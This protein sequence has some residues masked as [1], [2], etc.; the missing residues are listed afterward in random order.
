M[1]L[2]PFCAN[3]RDPRSYLR[4]PWV[5]KGHAYACNGQILVRLP[6]PDQP[7]AI[8]QDNPLADKAA[9]LLKTAGK[10]AYAPLPEFEQ[11]KRCTG[12][13]GDGKRL[14]LAC[15]DCDGEGYFTRGWHEYQC[16]ECDGEG[17]L[18]ANEGTEG[19]AMHDCPECGGFGFHHS[20]AKVGDAAYSTVYLRMLAAL[21]GLRICT[22]GTNHGAHF[23]FDG[24]EGLLMPRR[25]D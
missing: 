16:K 3:S 13:G 8:A 21:P 22:N 14:M 19:A 10:A 20:A 7:D 25:A 23:T 1:D 6:C 5:H 24:G 17:L 2:Q 18:D 12:C 4:A 11:P 9:D 15:E